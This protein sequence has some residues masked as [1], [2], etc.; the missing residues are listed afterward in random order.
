[1]AIEREADRIA[2]AFLLRDLLD[3]PGGRERIWRGEVTG[4]LSAGLFVNFGGGFDGMVPLASLRGDWWEMADEGTAIFASSS[5]A[6]DSPRRSR[7][8]DDRA[9]RRGARSRRSAADR[10]RRR[11]LAR[12][13][14]ATATGRSFPA[15]PRRSPAPV[16]V[17]R[18]A[19]SAASRIRS[20]AA[21]A[22]P[23]ARSEAPSSRPAHAPASGAP[24]R[25]RSRWR[26]GWGG[27]QRARCRRRARRCAGRRSAGRRSAART[28]SH[29]VDQAL[30][31]AVHAAMGDEH[32]G[33]REHGELRHRCADDGVA[34]SGPR[35]PGSIRSPIESSTGPGWSRSAWSTFRK[36]SGRSL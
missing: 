35:A 9:H 12:G 36:T 17:R 5:G 7:R 14:H 10:H 22:P 33:A 8:G 3:Q 4:M 21:A 1:M 2:K 18:G 26:P 31:G 34:R 29:A 13:S 11:P 24:H 23:Q 15:A 16:A 25:R 19:S 28:P 27:G 20:A 30:R 6:G 32:L